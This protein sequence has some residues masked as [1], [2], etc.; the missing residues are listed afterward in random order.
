MVEDGD[1]QRFFFSLERNDSRWREDLDIEL[2][3][4]LGES[5][6][7]A[8]EQRLLLY[9]GSGDP[10]IPRALKLSLGEDVVARMDELCSNASAPLGHELLEI[11]VALYEYRKDS[12]SRDLIIRT[13]EEGT[14]IARSCALAYARQL[15]LREALPAVSGALRDDDEYVRYNALLVLLSLSGLEV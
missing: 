14:T 11:A 6:R 1:L 9:L 2:L 12:T 15:S 8:A 3:L 4:R 5:D 7:A 13:M 10:R